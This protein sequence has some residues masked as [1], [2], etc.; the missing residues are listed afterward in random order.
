VEPEYNKGSDAVELAAT[1]TSEDPIPLRT[2]W[3]YYLGIVPLDSH[4]GTRLFV[5]IYRVRA[6]FEPH[7]DR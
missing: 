2:I 4:S 5:K 7:S 1:L 3:C 6:A